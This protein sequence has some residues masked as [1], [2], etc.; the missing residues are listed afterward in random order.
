MINGRGT[1]ESG[2]SKREKLKEKEDSYSTP[3]FNF[4]HQGIP[5]A[6]FGFYKKLEETILWGGGPTMFKGPQKS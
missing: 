3:N 4:H 1:Y 2:S 5:I 6:E